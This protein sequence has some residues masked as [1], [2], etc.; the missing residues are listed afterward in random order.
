MRPQN[1]E[2]ALKIKTAGL[3]KKKSFHVLF[4]VII[5]N[6]VPVTILQA[7]TALPRHI[8]KG[9]LIRPIIASHLCTAVG[10]QQFRK[11]SRKCQRKIMFEHNYSFF[12]HCLLSCSYVMFQKQ[13][14]ELSERGAH[15]P[16]PPVATAML[17]SQKY[18]LKKYSTDL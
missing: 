9:S 3:R 7:F 13:C 10:C 8:R 18:L 11:E 2:C 1:L 4:H 12:H 14:F 17:A 6:K 15:P 16:G 5:T